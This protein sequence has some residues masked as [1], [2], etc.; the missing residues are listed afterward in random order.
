MINAAIIGVGYWGP[1]LLRNL[2]DHPE[3]KVK[4]ICD[5]NTQRL[6]QF[7]W[8]HPSVGVTTR[9]QDVLNDTTVDLVTI[10]TPVHSHYDL[11]VAAL[12]AGK[13]VLLTKPMASSEKDCL[14][15]IELA[16]RRRKILMVDHTFVYHPAVAHLK[17]MVTKGELGE[18]L[19]FQSSRMNLGIYQ[20]DVSVI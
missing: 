5:A 15:L 6:N 1:N 7:T 12:N 3:I 11:A 14:R 17:E 18:L 20:P 16:A 9:V 2:V 4:W 10:A 19:Y 13:H 8:R